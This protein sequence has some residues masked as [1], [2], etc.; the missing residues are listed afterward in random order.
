M[1]AS[2]V[3]ARN[4]PGSSTIHGFNWKY[5]RASA[6][7]LPQLG[8]SGGVPAPRKLNAASISTADAQ[9]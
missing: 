1:I 6:M 2:T 7:M 5:G 4:T 8:I 9:M 3:T